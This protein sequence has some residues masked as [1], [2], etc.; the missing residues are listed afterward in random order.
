[1]LSLFDQTL[2]IE[3]IGGAV[4]VRRTPL[5]T[6]ATHHLPALY[7]PLHLDLPTSLAAAGERYSLTRARAPN[8][9]AYFPCEL[10]TYDDGTLTAVCCLMRSVANSIA[11]LP[12]YQRL[13][14]LPASRVRYRKPQAQGH[15]FVPRVFWAGHISIKGNARNKRTQFPNE[16]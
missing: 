15:F 13:P 2:L 7:T 6:W 9:R 14:V 10:V 3:S 1:M 16:N 12:S 11:K 5:G 8:A 4:L